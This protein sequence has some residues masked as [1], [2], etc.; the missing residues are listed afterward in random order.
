M[1]MDKKALAAGLF[2]AAV[3]MSVATP[4]RAQNASVTARGKYGTATNSYICPA[5]AMFSHG[6][7]AFDLRVTGK[8][9]GPGEATGI[10]RATCIGFNSRVDSTPI[11][12]IVEMTATTVWVR[13]LYD[14]ESAGYVNCVDRSGQAK[15]RITLDVQLQAGTAGASSPPTIHVSSTVPPGGISCD[16]PSSGLG[17]SETVIFQNFDGGV[18]PLSAG[19][20]NI[21]MAERTSSN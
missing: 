6:E 10:L 16:D 3:W 12:T 18:Q 9:N 15:S 19:A 20:I 4:A 1:M 2:V 17:A 5:I 13:G 8:Q 14:L 7:I 11:N 21:T